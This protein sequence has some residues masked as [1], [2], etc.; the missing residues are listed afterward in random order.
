MYST[1]PYIL[2]AN[3]IL[4]VDDPCIPRQNAQ[5]QVQNYS[6]FALNTQISGAGNIT[7][8]PYTAVT[9]DQGGGFQLTI[10]PA[11]VLSNFGGTVI[12]QWLQPG[13]SPPVADG[14]LMQGNTNQG[15]LQKVSVTASAP[16]VL[17][18][19]PPSGFVYRLHSVTIIGTAVENVFI[20]DPALGTSGSVFATQIPVAGAWGSS[21]LFNGLLAPTAL[22]VDVS[23]SA[24]V[25]FVLNY[26]VVQV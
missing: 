1:G 24:L 26:D 8:P 23:G 4:T 12:L 18:P 19:A 16:T 2:T 13:E 11:T 3:D 15:G 17:L 20:Y 22:S 7:I 10:T 6:G 25:T 9:M 5:V 14:V 21:F